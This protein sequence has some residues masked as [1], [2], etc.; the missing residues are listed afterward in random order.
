MAW[1]AALVLSLAQ[2]F[3]N[4]AGAAKKYL[5]QNL[6]SKTEKFFKNNNNKAII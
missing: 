2:E 5:V 3:L 6:T 1:F 4:A